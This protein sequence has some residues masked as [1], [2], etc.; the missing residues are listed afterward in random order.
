MADT[1]IVISDGP[2]TNLVLSGAGASAYQIWL[3]A[4]NTG[5]EQDFLDSL[6]GAT[7]PTG[8]TGA[9]GPQGPAGAT[10]SA[11]NGARLNGTIIELGNVIGDDAAALTRHTEI[12]LDGYKIAFSGAGQMLIGGT[13]AA[14]FSGTATDIPFGIVR[15]G[16]PLPFNTPIHLIT[17]TVNSIQTSVVASQIL[18]NTPDDEFPPFNQTLQYYPNVGGGGY[19]NFIHSEGFNTGTAGRMDVSMPSQQKNRECKFEVSAHGYC[20]EVW[21]STTAISGK[22]SRWLYYIANRDTLSNSSLF[23]E[24]NQF[25]IRNSDNSEAMFAIGKTGSLSIDGSVQSLISLET[26]ATGTAFLRHRNAADNGY[27][28]IMTASSHGVVFGKPGYDFFS[29]SDM[30]FIGKIISFKDAPANADRMTLSGNYGSGEFKIFSGA[31]GYFL[32]FYEGGAELMRLSSGNV[33]IGTTSNV[34]SA[35]LN[36]SST[37]KGFLPPRMT[38]TQRDAISSPAAGLMIYNTTTRKLNVFTTAWEQVTSA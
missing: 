16:P 14:P 28:D 24:A 19:N 10:Y 34:A 30:N 23:L 12:P 31:G 9:T 6:E 13:S 36:V 37:T 5:T 25:E 17:D 29:E 33:K 26:P 15:S 21:E 7:G 11:Q 2:A 8:P 3:D 27:L 38:T 4:G 20:Q 18:I 35:I 22:E 1:Y 32:T